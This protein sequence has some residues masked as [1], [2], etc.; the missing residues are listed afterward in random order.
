MGDA[1]RERIWED[2][3]G[4]RWKSGRVEGTCVKMGRNGRKMRTGE[5]GGGTGVGKDRTQEQAAASHAVPLH[6]W[7]KVALSQNAAICRKNL[8]N[9]LTLFDQ[10]LLLPSAEKPITMT[11]YPSP[12][13]EG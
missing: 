5:V 11:M 6:K 1:S 9:M 12:H 3:S 8:P 2:R 4:D 7:E 13:M 10:D